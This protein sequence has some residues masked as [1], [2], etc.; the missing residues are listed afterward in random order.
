MA[1]PIRRGF[2][3]VTVAMPTFLFVI[4]ADSDLFTSG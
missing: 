4:S 2:A 3:S 1:L